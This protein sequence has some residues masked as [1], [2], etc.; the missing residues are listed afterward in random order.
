MSPDCRRRY[1]GVE[2]ARSVARVA[3]LMPAGPPPSFVLFLHVTTVGPR[4]EGPH[5][6]IF[7]NA[8]RASG[9]RR[10]TVERQRGTEPT[11]VGYESSLKV[12]P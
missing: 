5:V 1:P 8:I 2:D 6:L 3:A 12:P 9:A 7:L 11:R 4:E 10:R